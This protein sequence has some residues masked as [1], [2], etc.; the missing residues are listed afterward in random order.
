MPGGLCGLVLCL[1]GALDGGVLRFGLLSGGGN[2]RTYLYLCLWTLIKDRW[3]LKI[4]RESRKI[5]LNF[6]I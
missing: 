5:C 4:S 2:C 3:K 1:V 6:W